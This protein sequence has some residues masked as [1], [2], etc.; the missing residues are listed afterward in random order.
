MVVIGMVVIGMFLT[1]QVA[2]T[3]GGATVTVSNDGWTVAA[4]AEQ[5]TLSG[6]RVN[7]GRVLKEAQVYLRG[8]RGLRRLK[9]WSVEKRGNSGL[10]IHTSEPRTAWDLELGSEVLRISTTSADG[11]LTGEAPAPP[12]RIVVRLLDPQGVP[13]TWRGTAE[14][15][16]YYGGSKTRNPSFLPRLNPEVMYLLWGR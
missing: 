4:E 3:A 14:V 16:M 8:E 5:A 12:D 7:L 15:E 6:S 10:S 2:G 1:V 13:V 9:G 11:V